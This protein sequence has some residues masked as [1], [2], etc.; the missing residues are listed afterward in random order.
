LRLKSH[1]VGD[2]FGVGAF[3]TQRS[4]SVA[5][6]VVGRMRLLGARWVRE[7][8]TANDVHHAT[9][10]SYGWRPY[11]R[12]VDAELRAGFRVLGLLDY[13]NS[14]GYPDH[15]T[16]PHAD[17]RRLAN[18]FARYAYAAAR[19]YRTRIRYWQVWNEPDFAEF[20]HPTPN[21][22]DYAYL[23]S[24]AY[25]ALKR[26]NR[27]AVVVMAGMSK[28][29]LAFIRQVARYTR[30]FNVVAV[31]PYRTLPE[32]GLLAQLQ[33]LGRLHRPIW[34]SEIGWAA[35]DGCELCMDEQDQANYLIRFYTLAAA[36]GAQRIF[37]YDLRDD[38]RDPGS[39]EGHFGLMRGDL[40][41]K[42]SFAAYSFLSRV[43]THARFLSA[44]ATG[45]DG[46]YALRFVRGKAPLL[47]LWNT[48]S[49]PIHLSIPWP[50]HEAVALTLDGRVSGPVDVEDG[51]VLL[52]AWPGGQP[53]YIAARAAGSPV[54]APG[55]LLRPPPPKARPPRR[56]TVSARHPRA[57]PSR[58]RAGNNGAW[59]VPTASSRTHRQPQTPPPG[60]EGKLPGTKLRPTPTPSPTS[61]PS[62]TATETSTPVAMPTVTPSP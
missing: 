29:D 52:T 41:G 27:H 14:W 24:E 34:I 58:R 60:H 15:A 4:Y 18:D 19:H 47:V 32:S 1:P 8:F 46:I 11:D 50:A 53:I 12:V 45:E 36:G 7:E 61:T 25:R 23:L 28:V 42:L 2:I 48:G 40:S 26:A 37:W 5:P 17:I 38:G 6:L 59:A 9:N 33:A 16:M 21:P 62:A 57:A 51:H 43:L 30:D 44:V 56:V 35:G 22:A 54:P 55:P 39:P 13:S 20:W 10:A 31:H 49:F 3:I